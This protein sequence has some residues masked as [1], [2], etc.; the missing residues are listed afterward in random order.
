MG[1]MEALAD[2]A[3]AAVGRSVGPAGGEEPA[4]EPAEAQKP[5]GKGEKR[6]AGLR[7]NLGKLKGVAVRKQSAIEALEAKELAKGKLPPKEK[8]KLEG[9]LGAIYSAPA[10]SPACNAGAYT[11]ALVG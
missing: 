8:S 3:S 7:T 10:E 9:A 5:K 4:E 2:A 6:L 1:R 11:G